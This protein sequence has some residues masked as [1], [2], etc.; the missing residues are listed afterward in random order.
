MVLS[1]NSHLM[2]IICLY[3]VI[4]FHVGIFGVMVTILGNGHGNQSSNLVKAVSI[5][6][7]ANTLHKIRIQVF[8]LQLWIDSKADWAL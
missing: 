7:C 3:T 6:H 4:W 5:S 1:N 2:M 8:S